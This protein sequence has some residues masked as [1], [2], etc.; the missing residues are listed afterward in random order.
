MQDLAT[1]ALLIEAETD[2]DL[3][4]VGKDTPLDE[5]IEFTQLLRGERPTVEVLLLRPRFEPK[6]AKAALAA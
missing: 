2:E 4:V 5:V 1:A 6:K 3:L